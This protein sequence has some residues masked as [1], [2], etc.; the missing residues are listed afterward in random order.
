MLVRQQIAATS[1]TERERERERARERE[2]EATFLQCWCTTGLRQSLPLLFHCPFCFVFR[3]KVN[4][5]HDLIYNPLMCLAS[6]PASRVLGA[7]HVL[8]PGS[9]IMV[10]WYGIITVE[11][12][13]VQFN[14][15]FIHDLFLQASCMPRTLLRA[16]TAWTWHPS[17][18]QSSCHG[19]CCAHQRCGR[20]IP[21][22]H[23]ALT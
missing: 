22:R 5:F 9:V 21:P 23:R 17:Q 4:H 7:K 19:R 8:N 12:R 3:P 11:P 18:P 16:S 6:Q 2:R 20:G 13:S 1:L 14:P 10:V 15:H